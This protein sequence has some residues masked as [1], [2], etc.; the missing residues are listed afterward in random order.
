M[1]INSNLVLPENRHQSNVSSKM[2]SSTIYLTK[3]NFKDLYGLLWKITVNLRNK[4]L[5]MTLK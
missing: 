5:E 2:L 1:I 4:F 3:Y